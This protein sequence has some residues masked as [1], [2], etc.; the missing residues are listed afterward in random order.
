MAHLG[1]KVSKA[2]G[3]I[4]WLVQFR[5][6]IYGKDGEVKK[7][8]IHSIHLPTEKEAQ[9]YIDEYEHIFFLEEPGKT[10]YDRLMGKRKR[11]FRHKL[12]DKT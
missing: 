6:R 7:D 12:K 1:K 9:E 8:I 10:K 4:S 11:R 2:T 5:K 3:R